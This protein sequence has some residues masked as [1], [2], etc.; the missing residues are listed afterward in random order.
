MCAVK[1]DEY[2]PYLGEVLVKRFFQI[3]ILINGNQNYSIDQ[4]KARWLVIQ[5]RE[6]MIFIKK[7]KRNFHNPEMNTGK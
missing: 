5:G 2:P 6:A 7:K 4:N 1:C 3:E